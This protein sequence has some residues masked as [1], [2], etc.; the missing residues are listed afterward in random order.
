MM[1]E[2][3]YEDIMRDVDRWRASDLFDF[4]GEQ[5][6]RM[7]VEKKQLLPLYHIWLGVIDD[8]DLEN[9]A[10][11]AV[12]WFDFKSVWQKPTTKDL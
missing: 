9:V 2:S 4:H 1:P 7:L 6:A 3:D 12:G 5:L 8:T 10:P 11:N